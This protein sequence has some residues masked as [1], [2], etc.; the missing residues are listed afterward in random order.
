MWHNP[1][2]RNYNRRKKISEWFDVAVVDPTLHEPRAVIKV[3]WNPA[4]RPTR[5]LRSLYF[6][7]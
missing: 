2:F 3:Q 6:V 1:T 5:W 4:L 7:Q